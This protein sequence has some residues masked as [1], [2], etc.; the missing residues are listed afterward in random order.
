MVDFSAMRDINVLNRYLSINMTLMAPSPE[1]QMPQTR[2]GILAESCKVSRRT[3]E[4]MADSKWLKLEL[5]ETILL[6]THT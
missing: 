5:C 4:L 1:Y 3:I 2:R 6:L